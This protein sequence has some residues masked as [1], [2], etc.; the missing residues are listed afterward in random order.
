MITVPTAGSG[1]GV[2]TTYETSSANE[3]ADGDVVSFT[4][5]GA[6][7]TATFADLTLAISYVPAGS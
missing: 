2:A 6:N 4:V 7:A 1:A 5:G 3:L